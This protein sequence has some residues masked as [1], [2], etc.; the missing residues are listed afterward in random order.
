MCLCRLHWA[1]G[2]RLVRHGALLHR[3]ISFTVAR[4]QRSVQPQLDPHVIRVRTMELITI[5][6][7]CRRFR[8]FVYQ[9]AQ[10][11]AG[12][13]CAE[14]DRTT[15]KDRYRNSQ[16]SQ[17]RACFQSAHDALRR[18]LQ[19]LCRFF[20][21]QAAKKAQFDDARFSGIHA[22]EA[23][24]GPDPTPGPRHSSV[25]RFGNFVQI[26]CLGVIER[27]G[28]AP[29]LGGNPSA[30]RLRLHRPT[31]LD[32][33]PLYSKFRQ[34]SHPRTPVRGGKVARGAPCRQQTGTVT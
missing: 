16:T 15:A 32:V 6:N 25:T 23:V 12:K 21:A 8:G 1:S 26:D 30:G 11:S 20:H 18:N 19:D 33:P 28:I 5:L 22:R 3:Q 27:L 29:S 34:A 9:K 7:R 13:N 17:A 4:C 24:K 31:A 2:F 10:F 14:V